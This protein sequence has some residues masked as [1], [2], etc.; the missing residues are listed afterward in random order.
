LR[1]DNLTQKS[2]VNFTIE[3]EEVVLESKLFLDS[4]LNCLKL[5]QLLNFIEGLKESDVVKQTIAM[6][7]LDNY[8]EEYAGQVLNNL[9]ICIKYGNCEIENKHF[10]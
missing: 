10:K 3:N 9:K 1:L 8:T 4:R 7:T 6:A 2:G 5:T